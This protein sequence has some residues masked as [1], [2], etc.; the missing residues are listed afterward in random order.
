MLRAANQVVYQT[1]KALLE[2]NYY[3]CLVLDGDTGH[4]ATNIAD[5]NELF[6]EHIDSFEVHYFQTYLLHFI[7]VV[8]RLL[9]AASRGRGKTTARET[10]SFPESNAITGFDRTRTKLTLL[11]DIKYELKWASAYSTAKRVAL[12][13]APDLIC[14]FEIGG[15]VPASRLSKAISIPFYT[16]YM[17]TIVYPYIREKKLNVV[18]PYVKGLSVDA[19]LHFMLN[20]GT[21]GDVVQEYLGVDPSTVRFRIDGVDKSKLRDLPERAACIHELNL[22]GSRK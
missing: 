15:A 7:N 1:V 5:L 8:K 21:K 12:A 14:G 22:T 2:D 9:T 3:V 19:A 11:S 10:V 13:H 18:R 17:G 4:E 6:P 16:K 20:D